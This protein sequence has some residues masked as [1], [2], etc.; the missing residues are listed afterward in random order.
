[1]KLEQLMKLISD[2]E[3]FDKRDDAYF[4]RLLPAEELSEESLELLSAAGT[5]PLLRDLFHGSEE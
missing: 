3:Q 5:K 1:M 2:M 4:S